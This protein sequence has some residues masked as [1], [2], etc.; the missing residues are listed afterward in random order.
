MYDAADLEIC[1]LQFWK[2]QMMSALG[3]ACFY[4]YKIFWRNGELMSSGP[5][6]SPK[7]WRFG[8]LVQWPNGGASL[9]TLFIL[10]WGADPI[11]FLSET[12]FPLAPTIQDIHE[13]PQPPNSL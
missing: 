8:D 11:R 5:R 12:H 1:T 6:I 13:I 3:S 9:L 10:W 4:F 2:W 7:F